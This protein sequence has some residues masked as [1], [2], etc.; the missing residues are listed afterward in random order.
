MLKLKTKSAT[1]DVVKNEDGTLTILLNN[2][3]VRYADQIIKD[4]G[5]VDAVLARCKEYTEDEWQAKKVADK[6]ARKAEHLAGI[7]MTEEYA[8]EHEDEYNTIF[9]GDKTAECTAEN[10]RQLLIH[11]N[12]RNWGM[13]HLPKMNVG[14][15]C[16]Q[17]DCGGTRATAIKLDSPIEYEGK[18]VSK[19]CIGAPEKHLRDYCNLR[20]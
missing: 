10:V 5:G 13:W 17:Y 19:F 1:Y 3:P 9:G 8:A 12:G 2:E 14:Y 7:R 18:K 15:T 4:M 6:A 11:L 20:Y 16:N